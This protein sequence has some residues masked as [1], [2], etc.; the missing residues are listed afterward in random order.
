MSFLP[1][2]ISSKLIIKVYNACNVIFHRTKFNRKQ[3]SR[4]EDKSA[5]KELNEVTIMDKRCKGMHSNQHT[6]TVRAAAK[7]QLTCDCSHIF[8]HNCAKHTLYQRRSQLQVHQG[9]VLMANQ[10]NK[11]PIKSKSDTNRSMMLHAAKASN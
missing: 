4:L 6:L 1:A 10:R 8:F 2:V 3:V 11:V 9:L 5:S 7:A